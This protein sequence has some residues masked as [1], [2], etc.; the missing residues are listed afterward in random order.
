MGNGSSRRAAA[1]MDRDGIKKIRSWSKPQR[2][3]CASVQRLIAKPF[4]THPG[5][6]KRAGYTT[7]VGNRCFPHAIALASPEPART[8]E[9]TTC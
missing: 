6:H 9:P 8:Q 4:C 2:V 7:P 1:Q 3:G 5:C